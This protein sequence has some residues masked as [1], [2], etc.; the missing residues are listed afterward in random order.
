MSLDYSLHYEYWHPDTAEHVAAMRRYFAAEI[1]PALPVERTGRTLDIG[2]GFGYAMLALG[3]R[4]ER[5]TGRQSPKIRPVGIGHRRYDV[6]AIRSARH[7]CGRAVARRA[8]AFPKR[9]ANPVAR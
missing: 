5:A 6:V 7:L 3:D 9:A 4:S 2:C 1:A 8:R